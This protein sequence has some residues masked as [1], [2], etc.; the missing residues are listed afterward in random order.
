MYHQTLQLNVMQIVQL[1]L[2]IKYLKVLKL[3]KLIKIKLQQHQQYIMMHILDSKMKIQGLMIYYQVELVTC[4][5]LMRKIIKLE[6][7]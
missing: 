6:F 2:Q 3:I 1:I 4:K 7:N 5:C